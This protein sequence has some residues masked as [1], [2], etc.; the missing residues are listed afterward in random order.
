MNED[1]GA[2][3]MPRTRRSKERCSGEVLRDEALPKFLR[4]RRSVAK[5][6]RRSSRTGFFA[7]ALADGSTDSFY[8]N[9]H[10]RVDLEVE[11][12]AAI[13]SDHEGDGQA[14]EAADHEVGDQFYIIFT[15][16]FEFSVVDAFGEDAFY[17][18]DMGGI[19]L[20]F[21]IHHNAV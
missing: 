4:E 9:I 1:G 6:L 7:A 3:R 21:Q 2:E 13:L 5:Q 19:E 10:D 18:L 11:T 12:G 20:V 14:P 17:Q 15:D 16:L 8:H